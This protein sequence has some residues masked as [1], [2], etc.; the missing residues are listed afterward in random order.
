MKEFCFTSESV[1]GEGSRRHARRHQVRERRH[2][3]IRK[4]TRTS[5]RSNLKRTEENASD[6]TNKVL[7][8]NVH[9]PCLT[10]EPYGVGRQGCAYMR[11]LSHP[12]P[13]PCIRPKPN[14]CFPNRNQLCPVITQPSVEIQVQ[15]TPLPLANLLD[16][17]IL[18]TGQLCRCARSRHA[19]YQHTVQGRCSCRTRGSCLSQ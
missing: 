19:L 5:I 6:P 2:L 16:H 12:P 15:L 18:R 1:T 3:P 8:V 7:H 10:E 4:P 17:G 9:L 14:P 13:V 11:Q